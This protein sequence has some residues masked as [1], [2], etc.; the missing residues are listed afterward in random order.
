MNYLLIL[1]SCCWLSTMAAAQ[2]ATKKSISINSTVF[3]SQRTLLV[4]T[5]TG[6]QLEPSN[7][8]PVLY[9]FGEKV[10]KIAD[11]VA[12]TS[13][14]LTQN[15][16]GKAYIIV[17]VQTDNPYQEFF[18]KKEST[19]EEA[20]LNPYRS[21]GQV[22]LMDQYLEKEVFPLIRNSYAVSSYKLLVGVGTGATYALYDGAKQQS[23]FK[24]YIAI[25]PQLLNYEEIIVDKFVRKL[26]EQQELSMYVYLAAAEQELLEKEKTLLEKTEQ[27]LN[28]AKSIDIRHQVDYVQTALPLLSTFGAALMTHDQIISAPNDDWLKKVATAPDFTQEVKS[29]YQKRDQWL[30][31]TQ[32]P[33]IDELVA[34]ATNATIIL[35]HQKGMD[36]LHWA[37][38]LYPTS[39]FLYK[40]RADLAIAQGAF[41]EAIQYYEEGLNVLEQQRKTM[42]ASAYEFNYQLLEKALLKATARQELATKKKG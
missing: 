16:K 22:T 12:S 34:L 11:V 41:K 35:E 21:Q 5:P 37:T 31:Y 7:S 4:Y 36:V 40:K 20:R 30:G 32:Q 27:A 3:N 24:S 9:V 23:L 19:T 29:Y 1:L 10:E 18:P 14:Y 39:H 17:G 6:Y 33:S 26:K 42:N 13:R 38:Q 2:T 15:R 25:S 28:T 8:Y